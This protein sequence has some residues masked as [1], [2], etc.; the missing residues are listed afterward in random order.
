MA[1]DLFL[2]LE[3]EMP[4][5]SN[6]VRAM[7]LVGAEIRTDSAGKIVDGHFHASGMSFWRGGG[8]DRGVGGIVAEGAHECTFL[9]RYVVAFRLSQQHYDQCIEDLTNFLTKL[10]EISKMQ[11]VLSLH[12]EGV[13]AINCVDRGL[14]FFWGNPR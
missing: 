6:F 7:E 8:E 12:Y 10:S 4:D 1:Q 2:E 14:Q 9:R 5:W 3:G 13:Y 11:F